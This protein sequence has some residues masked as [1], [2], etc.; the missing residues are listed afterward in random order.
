MAPEWYTTAVG[1][2]QTSTMGYVTAASGPILAVAAALLG[3]G[4]VISAIRYLGS[5]F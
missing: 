1:A 2:W 3:I 4:V 5:R